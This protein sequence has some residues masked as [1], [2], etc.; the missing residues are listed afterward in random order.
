VAPDITPALCVSFITATV[1]TLKA[2]GG[3]TAEL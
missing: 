3:K 2:E 1:C